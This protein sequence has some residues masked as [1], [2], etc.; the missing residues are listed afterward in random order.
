MTEKY[1]AIYLAEEDGYTIGTFDTLKDAKKAADAVSIYGGSYVT[2]ADLGFIFNR[3]ANHGWFDFKG[4]IRGR[5]AQLKTVLEGE[6]S[7]MA[8]EVRKLATKKGTRSGKRI[9]VFAGHKS[10]EIWCGASAQ[11]GVRASLEALGLEFE[12]ECPIKGKY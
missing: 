11:E 8:T 1:I 4:S 12:G 7:P 5:E 10:F 2:N 9:S 3:W 6:E